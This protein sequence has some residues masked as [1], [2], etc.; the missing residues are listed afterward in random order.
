MGQ[1]LLASGTGVSRGSVYRLL[2]FLAR[3]TLPVY[4]FFPITSQ[5]PHETLHRALLKIFLSALVPSSCLR[6]CQYGLSCLQEDMNDN[7]I[8][9]I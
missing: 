5:V 1:L 9:F 6:K 7:N 3:H 2:R 4:S 8:S